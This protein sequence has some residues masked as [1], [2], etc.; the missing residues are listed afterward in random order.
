MAVFVFPPGAQ[1]HKKRVVYVNF[2]L[3]L[4]G[5]AVHDPRV[6]QRFMPFVLVVALLIAFRVAGTMF[7]EALPNFQPLSAL[8]FCG[9]LL[10]SGWR[11]FAIPAGIWALTFPLG[12]GHTAGPGLF[13]TTLVGFVA[14]FFLGQVLAK[15]GAAS[16]LLGAVGAA[17]VFHLFTSGMAWAVDPRYAKTGLGLWQ[18]IW[19]GAPG[20]VLPSWVFLRNLAGANALFT[21]AVLLASV[22]MLAWPKLAKVDATA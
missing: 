20:D 6:M 2:R 3:A 11:G 5:W 10:A 8:F 4:G 21:A 9:V 13:L 16:M 19:L 17:A 18:S 1:E 14:V 22:K 12:V 7:P 15:R